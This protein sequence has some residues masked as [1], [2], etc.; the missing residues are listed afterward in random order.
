MDATPVTPDPSVAGEPGAGSVTSSPSGG[1]VVDLRLAVARG[2]H[3][4]DLSRA[5]VVFRMASVFAMLFGVFDVVHVALT[6]SGDL[7]LL[8]GLRAVCAAWLLVGFARVRRTPPISERELDVL[9]F[10]TLAVV[11]LTVSVMCV[12]TGGLTSYYAAGNLFVLS[13]TSYVPRP[14]R[15]TSLPVLF[16]ASLY[17]A[18]LLGSALFS[19]LTRAQLHQPI[20]LHHVA[21]HAALLYSTALFVIGGGHMVWS[22][23]RELSESRSIGRYELKRRLGKGGMGEVWAAYHRGLGREVALKILRVEGDP[24]ALAAT[25]FEREVRATAELAHPNTVRVFDHGA[26]PDGLVYYAMELLRGEHLRA[27]VRREGPLP[28][29][30]ALHLV[31]QAA[32]ALAEAHARGIVHRDVKPENLFVTDAGG[33]LDF[34]KVLDFGVAKLVRSGQ[35]DL[36]RVGSITGTPSTMSPEAITSGEIGP[37]ADV[38]ALGAVLYF[39][40]TGRMPFEGDPAT[41]LVAHLTEPVIPPSLRTTRAIPLDVERV[42]MRALAKDPAD[43]YAEAGAFAAA[44]ATCSAWNTWRPDGA[45]AAP[46]P[47]DEPHGGEDTLDAPA[48]ASAVT[49]RLA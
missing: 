31:G 23:R 21:V 20:A 13:G 43:R 38:Y 9:L 11:I 35:S 41:L 30:R 4:A 14:W 42:V 40:L 37:P 27:L 44:L 36:T 46:P 12:F 28:V 7:P 25:R 15:R 48:D 49:R 1:A 22:L 39:A 16:A 3:L 26:T 19:P 8:L 6:G 32:R 34:V 47:P 18:V 33:E 45:P 24:D 2:E 5:R 29:P 10:G 17:P